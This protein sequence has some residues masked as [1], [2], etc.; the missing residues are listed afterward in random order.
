MVADGCAPKTHSD[1]FDLFDESVTP[2]GMADERAKRE[3][4]GRQEEKEAGQRA[5]QPTSRAS[6]GKHET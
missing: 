3:T 1:F 5:S 4:R 6:K 2:R